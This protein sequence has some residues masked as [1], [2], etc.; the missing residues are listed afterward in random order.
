MRG[1]VGGPPLDQVVSARYLVAQRLD[2]GK[3]GC[4]GLNDQKGV[5]I[6]R[7]AEEKIWQREMGD[8]V[9]TPGNKIGEGILAIP[10]LGKRASPSN[11]LK[12]LKIKTKI[13]RGGR[14]RT[15]GSWERGILNR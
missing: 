15:W 3:K 14:E 13:E 11:R 9:N 10:S 2:E 6:V 8:L 7:G 4:A 1:L 5:F 12:T